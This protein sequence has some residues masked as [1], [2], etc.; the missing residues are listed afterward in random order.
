MLV[1]IGLGI[2]AFCF[3]FWYLARVLIY[4][5]IAEKYLK[6]LVFT[7]DRAWNT[8]VVHELTPLLTAA[9]VEAQHLTKYRQVFVQSVLSYISPFQK[10]ILLHYFSPQGLIALISKEFDVRVT[11]LLTTSTKTT[12]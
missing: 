4:G 8:F 9:G 3:I 5:L 6:V 11:P 12:T 1:F 10:R 2:C 7:C